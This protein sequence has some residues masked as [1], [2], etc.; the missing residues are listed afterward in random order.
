MQCLFVKSSPL[1]YGKVKISFFILNLRRSS[2]RFFPLKKYY[3]AFI[4]Q[5][6]KKT[7]NLMEFQPK[8]LK[9]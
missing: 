6:C 4:V 1:S 2:L 7:K 3:Y 8:S 5:K 9:F